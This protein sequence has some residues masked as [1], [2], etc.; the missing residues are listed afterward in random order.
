L[1]RGNLEILDGAIDRAG[2]VLGTYVHG[3]FDNDSF[4]H[5]FLD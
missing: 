4:R 2:H 3:F 1:T 5:S